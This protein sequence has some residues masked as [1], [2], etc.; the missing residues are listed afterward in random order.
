MKNASSW[1]KDKQWSYLFHTMSMLDSGPHVFSLKNMAVPSPNYQLL[2]LKNFRF[3]HSLSAWQENQIV[4]HGGRLALLCASPHQVL[5]SAH[6]L[7]LGLPITLALDFLNEGCAFF[8]R[9]PVSWCPVIKWCRYSWVWLK[10]LFWQQLIELLIHLWL[11]FP[12]VA[13]NTEK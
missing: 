3:S 12:F 1:L 11:H 8:P 10:G 7:W 9:L 13:C 5:D 2:E 4:S 6:L